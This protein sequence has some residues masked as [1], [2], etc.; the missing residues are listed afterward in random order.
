[1]QPIKTFK[2]K[3]IHKALKGIIYTAIVSVESVKVSWSDKKGEH[4]T[5]YTHE[6][7]EHAFK[8][9]HWKMVK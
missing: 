5:V 9:G 3:H 8:I 7:V 2:F 1:M 4:E 6:E